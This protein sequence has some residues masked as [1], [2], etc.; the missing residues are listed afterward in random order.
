MFY[1]EKEKEIAKK[2]HFNFF[3]VIAS[4]VS[5]LYKFL[6][7]ESFDYLADFLAQFPWRG[8]RVHPHLSEARKRQ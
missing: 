1:R 4:Q 5:P 6:G 7:S 8:T 3:V 2:A